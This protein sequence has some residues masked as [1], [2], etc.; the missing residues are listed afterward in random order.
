MK[1]FLVYDIVLVDI[2]GPIIAIT[3]F[4]IWTTVTPYELSFIFF[5]KIQNELEFRIPGKGLR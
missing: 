2:C 1:C 4:L 5:I 3:I